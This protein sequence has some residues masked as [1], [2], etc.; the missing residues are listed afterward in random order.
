MLMALTKKRAAYL[1]GLSVTPIAVFSI[2]KMISVAT[3]SIKVRRSSDNATQ[4]IG[5]VGSVLDTASLLAFCGAASGYI[6]TFYDQTGNGFNA[7]QATAANQPRIVNAGT[8]DG[9][10]YFDGTNSWAKITALTGG[11][12]QVGMYAKMQSRSSVVQ[13]FFESTTDYY[14]HA[15][16]FIFYNDPTYGF[17]ISATNAS[18]AYH[19]TAFGFI[20]TMTQVTALLNRALVYASEEAVWLNGLSQTGHSGAGADLSGNNGTADMYIGKGYTSGN[21]AALNLDTV[22]FYNNDTASIRASIESIVA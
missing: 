15:Q 21:P 11:T 5:F 13:Y 17:G 6:D 3:K 8:Y 7:V 2:R 20:P 4:D 1:D 22:A 19:A 12:P 18:T 10:V 14:N 9:F 16:A